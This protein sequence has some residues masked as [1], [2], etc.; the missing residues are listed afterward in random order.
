MQVQ[1]GFA[2]S[3]DKERLG[4]NVSDYLAVW[5]LR[6]WWTFNTKRGKHTWWCSDEFKLSSLGVKCVSLPYITSQY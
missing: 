3:S 5:I 1:T 2:E 4:V 6:L